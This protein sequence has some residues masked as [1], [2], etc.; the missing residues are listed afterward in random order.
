MFELKLQS[1]VI[2]S[3]NVE[4]T[5]CVDR[6][7]LQRLWENEAKNLHVLLVV[8]QRHEDAELSHEE[9]FLVPLEQGKYYVPVSRPG[10]FRI[11]AVVVA[12]RSPK[13]LRS[14]FY[15][16]SED[17]SWKLTV[18]DVH[19]EELYFSVSGALPITIDKL[20]EISSYLDVEVP[21]GIFPKRPA[22]WEW[23]TLWLRHIPNECRYRKQRFVAYSVQPL[24]MA[25]LAICVGIYKVLALVV[26]TLMKLGYL[27]LLLFMCTRLRFIDFSILWSFRRGAKDLHYKR[28]VGYF[29][30]I[31]YSL[32]VIDC[33]GKK[34]SD[35]D[36]ITLFQTTW[37]GFWPFELALAVLVNEWIFSLGVLGFV[38]VMVFFLPAAVMV[39]GVLA[40]IWDKVDEVLSAKAGKAVSPK[41]EKSLA[42]TPVK[43]VTR[44]DRKLLKQYEMLEHTVSCDAEM[45]PDLRQ[46]YLPLKTKAVLLFADVKAKVCRPYAS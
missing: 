17:G 19:A 43:T 14:R 3:P 16:K 1:R 26:A 21:D 36:W 42:K 39:I 29:D 15:G 27:A 33:D 30:H 32:F 4:V 22:D 45:L 18:V 10:G 6:H 46:Q 2:S 40:E 31:N 25:F 37:P 12:G 35:T 41:T 38:L 44:E 9:R 7:L 28:P 8:T 24:V 20:S 34:R 11:F 23:V 13:K 5:W